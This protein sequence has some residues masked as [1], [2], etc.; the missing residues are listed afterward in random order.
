MFSQSRRKFGSN[1]VPGQ[2]ASEITS[3]RLRAF[4]WLR[5]GGRALKKQLRKLVKSGLHRSHG[6]T[7]VSLGPIQAPRS[8]QRNDARGRWSRLWAHLVMW[9]AEHVRR[10]TSVKSWSQRG[11]TWHVLVDWAP[12]HAADKGALEG[13]PFVTF[14][15]FWN[16]CLVANSDSQ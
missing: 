3:T 4:V 11:F 13:C 5:L 12:Q 14:N 2:I 15:N 9:W 1:S 7:K 6:T 10:G 16:H 8:L